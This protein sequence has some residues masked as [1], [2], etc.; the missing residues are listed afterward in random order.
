[1]Q[2]VAGDCYKQ[3]Y[4][5]LH[6]GLYRR[7]PIPYSY[8]VDYYFIQYFDNLTIMEQ[9]Q[10]RPNLPVFYKFLELQSEF[11][12][13]KKLLMHGVDFNNVRIAGLEEVLRKLEYLNMSNCEM[14]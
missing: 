4:A 2:Q 7:N 6:P 3:N 10:K 12:R 14:K 11:N 13:L 1:M 5:G 9:F 8:Y